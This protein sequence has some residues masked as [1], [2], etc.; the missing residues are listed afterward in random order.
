MVKE[1][2]VERTTSNS[3]I[4]ALKWSDDGQIAIVNG[5]VVNV[6]NPAVQK[7]KEEGRPDELYHETRTTSIDELEDDVFDSLEVEQDETFT[8]GATT[9]DYCVTDI[10]WSPTGMSATRTCILGVLTNKNEVILYEAPGLATSRKWTEV[11]ITS[12]LVKSLELTEPV[13]DRD[14]KRL[15]VHSLAWSRA[16]YKSGLSRWGTSFLAMGT[17][18]GHVLLWEVNSETSKLAGAWEVGS[19]CVINLEWAGWSTESKG[20][21]LNISDVGDLYSDFRCASV[22]IGGDFN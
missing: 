6:F 12:K 11:N 5:L 18:S 1:I 8:V 4:N 2:K 17:E 3:Y 15:R 21:K 20:S 22:P 13:K 16:V 14:V 9:N 19:E 10:C 7:S